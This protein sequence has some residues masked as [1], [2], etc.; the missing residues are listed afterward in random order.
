MRGRGSP[1][2]LAGAQALE[3]SFHR[4]NPTNEGLS[5]RSISKMTMNTAGSIREG[6]YYYR[7]F[8]LKVWHPVC[9]NCFEQHEH[10]NL[11]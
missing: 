6:Y 8:C 11:L 2:L 5:V 9:S 10:L 3:G 7:A 1:R 4:V